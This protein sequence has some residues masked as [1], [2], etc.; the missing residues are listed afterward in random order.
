MMSQTVFGYTSWQQ[1]DRDIMPEVRTVD[2]ATPRLDVTPVD[3]YPIG[4]FEVLIGTHG[5]VEENG[6]IAIEA[7]HYARAVAASGLDWKTIANLGRTLG[8]V[9]AFPV[10]ATPQTPGKGAQLDYD[11]YLRAAGD[12]TLQVVTAPTLDFRGRGQLS[13]AVSIDDQA[14]QIVNLATN[15]EGAW[16]K[17]VAQNAWIK[18]VPVHVDRAG[19]HVI[20]LWQVDPGVDFERLV[21]FRGTLPKSYL[22]PPESQRR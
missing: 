1:P 18:E 7:P 8:A 2:P 10:T 17:A 6:I 9:A 11:V 22:G 15:D 13:Y 5:F 20:H 12:A 3:N 21:L 19:Q 14:P 4:P 16:S